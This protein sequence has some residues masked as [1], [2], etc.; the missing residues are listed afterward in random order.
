MIQT[1]LWLA[2]YTHLFIF[3][4]LYDTTRK[5]LV[6]WILMSNPYQADSNHIIRLFSII[7]F[8]LLARFYRMKIFYCVCAFEKLFFECL[9]HVCRDFFGEFYDWVLLERYDFC[10]KNFICINLRD[11]IENPSNPI[12]NVSAIKTFSVSTEKLIYSWM[13]QNR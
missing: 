2:L 5:F 10:I 11:R 7:S 3:L 13:T 1:D 6:H 12:V 8:Y 9:Q 4:Q